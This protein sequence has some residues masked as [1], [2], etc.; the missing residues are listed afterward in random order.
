MVNA[1]DVLDLSWLYQG[2]RWPD[3]LKIF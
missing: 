1:I 3:L 2:Q